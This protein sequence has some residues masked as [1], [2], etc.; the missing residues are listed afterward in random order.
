LYE[1]IIQLKPAAALEIGCGNGMHIHNLHI[2]SPD[3]KL[4]G[5]DRSEDQ[6]AYLREMNPHLINSIKQWDAAEPF[7]ADM[8][9]VAIDIAYSQAVI[10]HIKEGDK[11][12]RALQNMFRIAKKQ[13][14]LLENWLHHDFM[15]DILSLHK[16]KLISWD[17]LYLY[18]RAPANTEKDNR[19]IMICSSVPLQYP[20]LTDYS[21]LRSSCDT[22]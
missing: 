16:Q 1:T 18:Y 11:H 15:E 6:I 22:Y 14:V 17:K 4:F 7:T 8:F 12:L 9:P 3:I 2:L 20:V 13:V 10:M 21:V 5:I 19:H